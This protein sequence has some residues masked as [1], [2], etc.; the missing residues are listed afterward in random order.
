MGWPDGYTSSVLIFASHCQV[1]SNLKPNTPHK[2]LLLAAGNTGELTCEKAGDIT[3]EVTKVVPD[4][5]PS[6]SFQVNAT[7]YKGRS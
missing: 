5:N 1:P 4:L 6:K 2:N 3:S 7:Q